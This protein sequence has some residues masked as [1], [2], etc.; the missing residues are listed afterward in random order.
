MN[1]NEVKRWNESNSHFMHR[2]NDGFSAIIFMLLFF[3]NDVDALK[4][5]IPLYHDTQIFS[6]DGIEIFA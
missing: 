1:I 2:N 6:Y 5:F 3:N 4:C